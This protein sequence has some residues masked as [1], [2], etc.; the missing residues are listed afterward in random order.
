MKEL[1]HYLD[2]SITRHHIYEDFLYD[3]VK[4]FP[5]LF[6]SIMDILTRYDALKHAGDNLI[7]LRENQMNTFVRARAKLDT[8]VE[9]KYFEIAGL[10]AKL[11]DYEK[12]YERAR[13]HCQKWE[14]IHHEVI[15]ETL[16]KFMEVEAV[17]DSC[18]QI[19]KDICDRKKAP[20]IYKDNYPKQFE[21][22]KKTL[23]QHRLV[24]E[25]IA[26]LEEEKLRLSEKACASNGTG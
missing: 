5:H 1:K 2:D 16:N 23:L 7:E 19:Y 17:K 20:T 3:V 9:E 11:S 25:K 4:S 22:I 12:H 10:K 13:L 6:T 24:N 8:F 14:K 26:V 18:W 21:V 15:M